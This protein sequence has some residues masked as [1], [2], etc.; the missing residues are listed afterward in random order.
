MEQKKKIKIVIIVLAILLGLSLLVLGGTLIYNK[1][2]NT[3]HA[4]VTVPDISDLSYE[5]ITERYAPF[6]ECY[7]PF[8]LL[9]KDMGEVF[10]EFNRNEDKF[11]KRMRRDDVYGF[12]DGT[13]ERYNIKCCVPDFAEALFRECF[14]QQLVEKA[15][16]LLTPIQQSRVKQHIFGKKSFAKI[17]ASEGKAKNTIQESYDAAIKKMKKFLK[18]TLP[19]D[20]PY[21]E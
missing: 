5:Q 14:P 3:T 20:T 13:T 18:N 19:K 9:S 7:L 17:A 16:A 1:I 21:S 4:T 12:E 8:V 15:F 6:V 2:A 11:Y 10:A